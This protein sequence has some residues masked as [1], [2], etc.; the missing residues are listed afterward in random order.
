[1]A[2]LVKPYADPEVG[3]VG[4]RIAAYTQSSRTTVELFSDEHSPL[5]NFSSGEDEFLP[6]L[7]TANASYRRTLLEDM[8]GFNPCLVTVEDVDLSW[9]LQLRKKAKIAYAPEA[10]VYHHHR[11]TRSGLARQYRH[12]GFGEI[13]IDTLYGKHPGYPRS[14]GYQIRRIVGQVA[15]LPRYALSAIVRRLRLVAGRA[16]PYQAD[17]PGLWL[18][19]ESNNVRGKLEGLVVTRLM[20][21]AQPALNTQAEVMIS[22]FFPSRKE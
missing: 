15:A 22:R 20:T 19:I 21:D 3:G 16:T 11:A 4:G 13:L 2:E 6:H 5:V 17:I 8:G 7:Y 9:R 1:L 18:L 14:R 12:Y 10:I